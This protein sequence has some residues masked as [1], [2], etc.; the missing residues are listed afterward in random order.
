M[1]PDRLTEGILVAGVPLQ[2]RVEL[3][4]ERT[5]Q[6]SAQAVGY[7]IGRGRRPPDGI[8]GRAAPA[9]GAGA[10][11]APGRDLRVDLFRGFSLLVL[12]GYHIPGNILFWISPSAIGF[13]DPAEAF[14]YLAGYSAGIAQIGRFDRQGWTVTARHIWARTFE[15]YRWHIVLGASFL[16]LVP[17][18]ATW[19]PASAK[20]YHDFLH[21]VRAHPIGAFAYLGLELQPPLLNILPLFIL[22][23][24]SL[25]LALPLA[26]RRPAALFALSLGGYVLARE[27]LLHMPPPLGPPQHWF[28]DPF[29]WQLVFFLGVLAGARA[30]RGLD[31]V[32]FHRFLI[33]LAIAYLLFAFTVILSWYVPPVHPPDWLQAEI[34]RV[35]KWTE[36]PL[37][38]LHFLALTYLAARLVSI[39]AAWLRSRAALAVA[40]VGQH[41]LELFA[42]GVVLSL[43]GMAIFDRFGDGLPQQFAVD[44]VGIA[45]LLAL[46]Q[47]LTRRAQA[48]KARRSGSP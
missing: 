26:A 28:F 31:V 30:G 18:I 13:S 35:R 36:S 4:R 32:P 24:A 44:I 29:A 40:R 1:F 38:L 2:V 48:A 45:L 21:A 5:W 11:T 12:F 42:A 3:F 47:A 16:V 9:A 22:L 20:P 14:V 27:Q 15:I 23:F 7:L 19:A 37:R 25:P 17:W 39:D 43:L 8:S 34:G 6:R 33:A 10:R 41:S 46:A